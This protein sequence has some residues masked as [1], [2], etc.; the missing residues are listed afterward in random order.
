MVI[1]MASENQVVIVG[2][3]TRDP[4]LRYTPNGA[5]LVKFGVAVSRRIKDEATGQWKDADTSFFDVTAWR[6]M[7]ENIAESITQGSRV[8]VVG[9]L[10]TNSWETPEGEKRH[11]IEIEAE[12]VAP[13]LKWATA[14][15]DRQGRGA[16]GSDWHESVTVG[17]GGPQE[18][19]PLD[20]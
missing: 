9:R 17:A 8:V 1:E 13:S 7:A 6:S 11:K 12:E 19:T 10:R 15:I 2:N 16:G 5:A 4:E 3:V 20:A 14:K 18:E